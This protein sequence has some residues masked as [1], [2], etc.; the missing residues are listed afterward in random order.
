V[1]ESLTGRMMIYDA[2][3]LRSR[4][5]R[6]RREPLCPACGERPVA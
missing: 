4:V 5:L 6:L 2:L 1:G 3:D